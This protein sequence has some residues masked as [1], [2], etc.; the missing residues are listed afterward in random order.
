MSPPAILTDV[1]S[2][3]TTTPALG[4]YP[5]VT[6]TFAQS[7]DAKIG[8]RNGS[9]LILSGK[10][11]MIMTHWMRTMHGA[12]LIGI[13]TALNDNPQLNTRHLPPPPPGAAPYHLPRPVILDAHLRL[14]P[15]CKLL[16]NYKSGTGRRPWVICATVSDDP[17]RTRRLKALENAGARVIQ[18]SGL[19]A[20]IMDEGV[21]TLPIPTILEALYASGIHSVM[22]EGG[23]RVIGSFF[24]AKTPSGDSIVDSLIVTVAPTFVGED[25]VG[26]GQELGKKTQGFEY[27]KAE[28]IGRDMVVAMIATPAL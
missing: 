8:R 17:E 18:V 9:Q 11:S 24:S 14:P 21:S 6:L 15:T 2:R 22:V 4:P 26:Y 10:E 12:I 28:L 5:H 19:A 13:G 16:V 20:D 25:G 27:V 1:L 7:L 23:A 3:Y